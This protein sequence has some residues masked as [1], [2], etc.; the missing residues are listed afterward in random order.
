ME[1]KKGG[2]CEIFPAIDPL[3]RDMHRFLHAEDKCL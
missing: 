3:A 1:K 2:H